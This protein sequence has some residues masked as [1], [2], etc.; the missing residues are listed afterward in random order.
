MEKSL[1]KIICLI[2]CML[3]FMIQF[4]VVAGNISSGSY[5]SL[6]PLSHNKPERFV[7]ITE[8]ENDRVIIINT[9]GTIVWEKTGLNAPYDADFLI[10]GNILITELYGD[11]VIE[12]DKAGSIVWSKTGLNIPHDADR[13]TNGNTLISETADQCVIEVN[14]QGDIV[15]E[16]SGLNYPVEAERCPNGNTLIVECPNY[17]YGRVIEVNPSGL[18]VWQKANLDYPFDAERLSNGNTLITEVNAGRVIEVNPAG[19]IVWQKTVFLPVDAERLSNGNTLIGVMGSQNQI[20]EVNNAGTIVWQISELNSLIDVEG[21]I[22]EAPDTPSIDG[23]TNGQVGLSYPYTICSN[24][25]DDDNVYYY[26]EWGDSTTSGWIGPYSS[27]EEQTI[28]HTWI[29]KNTYLVQV[30][31]KDIWGA[32]SDWATLSVTIPFSYD[33][34]FQQIWM[35][36]LERFPNAFPILR[37]LFTY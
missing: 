11:R 34:P 30:K 28:S 7:L 6:L 3:I 32:E 27:G 2:S 10:N 17:E 26:I 4:S 20:I 25:P 37:H 33:I 18:I 21:I 15:W 9:T 1:K 8:P 29:K 19:T 24:D 36:I 12:V 13:T 35:R 14:N 23:E 22:T 5:N 16:K 31:V